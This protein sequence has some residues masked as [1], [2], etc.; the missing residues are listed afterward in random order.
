MS[1]ITGEAYWARLGAI[2]E[3]VTTTWPYDVWS[4][5]VCNLD[6]KNITKAQKDGLN[7]SSGM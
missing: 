4:I 6:E 5:D 3:T 7:S 1:V 2:D